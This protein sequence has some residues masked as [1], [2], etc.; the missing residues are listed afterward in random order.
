MLKPEL[1][2]QVAMTA[3]AV[4]DR[5]YCTQPSGTMSRPELACLTS[6]SQNIVTKSEKKKWIRIEKRTRG[7]EGR[8]APVS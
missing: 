2:R 8:A 5:T 6:W 3:A 4:A 1:G 7:R